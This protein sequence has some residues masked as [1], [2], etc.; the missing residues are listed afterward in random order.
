MY[1]LTKDLKEPKFVVGIFTIH[2]FLSDEEINTIFN[3]IYESELHEGK[4][5]LE[6]NT[7]TFIHYENQSNQSEDNKARKSIISWLY[8]NKTNI[9]LKKV[10]EKI[11]SKIIEV[12][13][14][15]FGFNLTDVEPFQFTTYTVGEYYKKHIDMGN[16]LGIGNIQRKLSFT[17]QLSDEK[18]Y[19]G[20]DLCCYISEKLIEASKKKGSISFF[21]SFLLHEVKEVTRGKRCSLVGWVH[22]PR[23]V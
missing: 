17:I 5:V 3:S 4:A 12:N 7:P 10:F 14:E 6:N 15:E 21:P 1:S 13:K 18:D 11:Y 8:Y 9:P 2:D 16:E 20:G 23:F 22:G 19:D